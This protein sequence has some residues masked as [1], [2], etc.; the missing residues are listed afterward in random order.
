MR[1]SQ[2]IRSKKN[3]NSSLGQ[4]LSLGQNFLAAEFFSLHRYFIETATTD[5]DVLLQV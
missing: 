2:V 1:E 4:N 5:I 3:Q